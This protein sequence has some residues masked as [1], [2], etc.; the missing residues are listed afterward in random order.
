MPVHRKQCPAKVNLN[1]ALLGRDDASGMHFIDSIVAKLSLS[2]ALWVEERP[3]TDFAVTFDTAR[4]GADA[5]F[6]NPQ[7]NTLT[8]AYRALRE[9]CG[10]D[11]PGL[12][13]RV[14]KRIPVGSGLGGGSSDAAGLLRLVRSLAAGE[15]ALA[16]RFAAV[17][18]LSE[19]DWLSIAAQA[20]ADVP[21]FMVDGPV[22]VRGFGERV[23]PLALP[24]LED[25]VCRLAFSNV[26]LSTAEMYSRVREYSAHNHTELFLEAWRAQ[27]PEAAFA[28]ARNDFTPIARQATPQVAASLDLLSAQ[29]YPLVAVTGSGSAVFAVVPRHQAPVG[30]SGCYEFLL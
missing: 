21:A 11:L 15:L 13:V 10:A 19:A 29:G 23:E 17:R 28:R 1:L 5:P 22:R 16:K 12:S 18:Q 27:G 26:A 24:G 25:F 3:E 4:L 7:D 30:E 20:G 2:D 8:R 14:A 9:A 6:I